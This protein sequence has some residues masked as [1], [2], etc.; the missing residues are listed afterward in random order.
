VYGACIIGSCSR[1]SYTCVCRLSGPGDDDDG[2]IEQIWTRC[3]ECYVV[4]GAL[5]QRKQGVV[6]EGGHFDL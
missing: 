3:V 6:V 1:K 4:E 5:C 2:G